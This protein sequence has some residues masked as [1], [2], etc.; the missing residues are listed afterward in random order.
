MTGHHLGTEVWG[1]QRAGTPWISNGFGSGS[2]NRGKKTT[3]F[4]AE[5]QEGGFEEG[6]AK[7]FVEECQTTPLQEYL[8]SRVSSH[9]RWRQPVLS[10]QMSKRDCDR[11]R[12]LLRKTLLGKWSKFKQRRKRKKIKPVTTKLANLL[13]L[14]ENAILM[15]TTFKALTSHTLFTLL[16]FKQERSNQLI[17]SEVILTRLC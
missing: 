11:N 7:A 16:L 1:A 10:C 2:G 12:Y 9:S 14:R 13:F 17:R 3:T 5:E 8:L 6:P 4:K 15:R